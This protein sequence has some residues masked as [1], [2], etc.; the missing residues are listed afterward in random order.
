MADDEWQSSSSVIRHPPFI[1]RHPP[2]HHGVLR[3]DPA[4]GIF[5]SNFFQRD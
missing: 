4:P 1:I 3:I 2:S 5:E